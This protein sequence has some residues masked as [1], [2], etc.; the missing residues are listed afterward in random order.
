MANS[1]QDSVVLDHMILPVNSLAPSLAFYCGALGFAKG[2]VQGP[3]QEVR[4][5]ETFVLLLSPYGTK[6]GM[7]LAFSFPPEQFAAV[8][9]EVRKRGL[10]YGDNFDATSNGLGPAPQAGATG[11]VDAI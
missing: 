8:F 5:S 11:E 7:H 4:V 10:S 3:F 9:A 1:R 6:G 2:D